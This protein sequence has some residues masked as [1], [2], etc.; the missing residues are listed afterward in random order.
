LKY[1]K[2]LFE[3]STNTIEDTNTLIKMATIDIISIVSVFG[4]INYTHHIT[5]CDTKF[6]F[7]CITA[8]MTSG[9]IIAQTMI[10]R[11]QR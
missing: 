3:I 2:Y 11:Y 6:D 4:I 7:W 1:F 10:Y 8:W 5:L 9:V